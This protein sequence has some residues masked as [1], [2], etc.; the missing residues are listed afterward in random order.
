MEENVHFLYPASLFASKSPYLVTTILGSCVAVCLY[1]ANLQIGGINHYML[2]LWNG[3]GLA[4]PKYG[5]IAI[6]KLIEKMV[7]LG[8]DRN[9]LKAKVFGGGEVIET[10]VTQFN[11]GARNIKLAHEMLEELKIPIV[12]QSVGGKLGRKILFNTETFE[13]KQKFIQKS[14]PLDHL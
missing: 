6:E 14:N 7:S 11:I 1:D 9:N 2:P 8:C 13:V 5:N 3:Q 4:S 10:T 12:G